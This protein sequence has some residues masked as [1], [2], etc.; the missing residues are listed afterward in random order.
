[1]TNPSLP[2]TTGLQKHYFKATTEQWFEYP[3]KVYPHHT[4]YGGVVWHGAYLT[5]LEES[6]V[7]SLRLSGIEYS[8][9]VNLGYELPVIELSLRYHHPLRLGMDAVVRSRMTEIDGVRIHWDNK[10]QSPDGQTVFVSARVTLV[11]IDS[12]K[13]KIMRQLP[14][15]VKDALIKLYH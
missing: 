1:M 14:V 8:D 2:P 7:E 12:K 15:T 6:R 3:I 11:A 10:I 4:D 13:G 5:W 9:L